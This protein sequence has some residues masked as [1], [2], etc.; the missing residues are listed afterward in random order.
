MILKF[1]TLIDLCKFQP[2]DPI[3]LQSYNPISLIDLCKFQPGNP[4]ILQSYNPI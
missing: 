3:I 1:F 2:G 4:I